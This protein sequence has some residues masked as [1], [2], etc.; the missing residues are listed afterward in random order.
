MRSSLLAFRAAGAVTVLVAAPAVGVTT[1][2]AAEA[3]DSVQVTVTPSTIAP[4]GE[5]AIKVEGCDSFSGQAASDAFVAKAELSG[6][7][8]GRG[9]RSKVPIFGETT[10][11]SSA[12]P[13]GYEINVRCGGRD[14]AGAGSFQV[15]H[16]SGRPAHEAGRPKGEPA[17]PERE[18]AR[19]ER[20][21]AQPD[22]NSVR[23]EEDPDRPE[24]EADRPDHEGARPDHEADRPD[25]EADR[26]DREAG[27]PEH[28]QGR[29]E[30]DSGRQDHDSGLPEHN[31]D[32]PE[33]GANHPEHEGEHPGDHSGDHSGDHAGDHAGDHSDHSDHPNPAQSPI[34]PVRAGGGGTA[35]LA[36]D[37]QA[38]A[39]RS[40]PGAPHAMVGLL[41]TAVAAIAVTF[42]SVRRRRTAV[43]ES[44]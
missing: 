41:L 34:A 33:Q 9:G 3:R 12:K 38:A 24:R 15:V 29:P 7:E 16:K 35:V 1:A 21:V 30:H 6:G 10:V 36:A 32:H 5:V 4:G 44:D 22:H 13:G 28:D 39:D 37:G 43:R 25:G 17:R 40:G 23:R 8:G 26:P 31:S 42:R 20:K 27:R 14:H 19:P 18:E 2:T 11:K